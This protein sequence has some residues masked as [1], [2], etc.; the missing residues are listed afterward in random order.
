MH[1][2]FGKRITLQVFALALILGASAAVPGQTQPEIGRGSDG[3]PAEVARM[4]DDIMEAART[5]DIEAMRPVLESNEL[6]PLVSG[7][8]V[9]DIVA[10]WRKV[11]GDGEGREILAALGETLEAG[12]VRLNP[13]KPDEIYVWPYFAA[14]PL[15]T[16]SPAQKVEL[17]RLAPAAAVRSAEG[18]YL[19]Y[20][21]GIGADGTWH[22]FVREE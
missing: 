5:G 13:G 22:Y 8:H 12:H 11:S 7:K 6:S 2:G 3:L 18:K 15:E 19:W 4:R 20:R 21:L 16:L 1:C 10:Y 9:D 14:V 17:F